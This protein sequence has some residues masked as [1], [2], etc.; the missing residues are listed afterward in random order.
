MLCAYRN[1]T[2]TF[3]ILRISNLP[4][5]FFERVIAPHQDLLFEVQ[6]QA[7]LE[8]YTGDTM[9]ALLA[10]RIPCEQLRVEGDDDGPMVE[11]EHRDSETGSGNPSEL[12]MANHR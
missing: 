7:L 11:V 5:L 10:A 9:S 2:A 1:P 6:A 8:I 3:Q 4:S 12:G